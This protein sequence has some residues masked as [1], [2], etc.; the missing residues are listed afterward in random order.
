M[1]TNKQIIIDDVDVSGCYSLELDCNVYYCSEYNRN[2]HCDNNHN[3]HYKQLQRKKAEYEELKNKERKLYNFLK[4]PYNWSHKDVWIRNYLLH[5]LFG[6]REHTACTADILENKLQNYKKALC[7]I[8][9]YCNKNI[10]TTTRN[11][12]CDYTVKSRP[13]L[14]ILDIINKMKNPTQNINEV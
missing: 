2:V 1:T 11:Y 7:E 3:C 13:L 6:E 8:E 5:Y 14:P 4:N 12:Y 9:E 10:K